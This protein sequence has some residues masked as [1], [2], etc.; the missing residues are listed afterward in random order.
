MTGR[1]PPCP[2]LN[3]SSP[4]WNSWERCKNTTAEIR[5]KKQGNRFSVT[6]AANLPK[7]AK[8]V[9]LEQRNGEAAF[10]KTSR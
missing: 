7:L 6:T 10:G 3:P 2:Y 8:V 9:K 1:N 5:A 4:E